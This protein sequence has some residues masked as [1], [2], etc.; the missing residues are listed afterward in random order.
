MARQSALARPCAR[1]KTSADTRPTVAF[2]VA[3]ASAATG[4]GLSGCSCEARYRAQHRR[5]ESARST[6]SSS[7]FL[8]ALSGLRCHVGDV[9]ASV[10]P[11]WHGSRAHDGAGDDSIST[12]HCLTSAQIR[13][14]HPRGLQQDRVPHPCNQMLETL[15]MLYSGMSIA[16]ARG[17]STNRRQIPGKRWNETE[18]ALGW[19][20]G[21]GMVHHLHKLS[22]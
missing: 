20:G 2:A 18:R 14:T 3:S 1:S 10:R 13:C 11:R 7:R 4:V 21:V 16:A 22:F 5:E 8:H 6:A 19:L 9:D 15:T 17:A 12:C